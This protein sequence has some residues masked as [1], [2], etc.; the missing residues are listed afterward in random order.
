MN[1]APLFVFQLIV[2]VFSVMV[3]ELSHGAV[4]L[5]L[6]DPTAKTAGRLTL[7][8]LKHLDLFGSLL[9]PLLLFL[10]SGGALLFGW[11][12]PVPYNPYNLR[13]PKRGSGIIAAAGPVSNL[14]V[15]VVFGILLRLTAPALVAAGLA[16]LALLFNL[17][18]IINVAL[19]VFNLLPIPPLDGAGVLF[20]ILPARYANLQ[21]L[22]TRY[23]IFIL[24]AVIVLLPGFIVPVVRAVYRLIVGGS[25]IL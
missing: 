13:N 9:L 24:I 25:G 21:A 1:Q 8:P 12:K 16:T 20:S 17:I 14:L 5:R 15:A 3:H 22:L 10:A 11:A 4:A 2:L 6:G 19:A 18:V 7:N 23:G